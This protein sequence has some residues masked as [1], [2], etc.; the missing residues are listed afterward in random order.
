MRILLQEDEKI[1][2]QITMYKAIYKCR[3]CGEEFSTEEFE[4]NLF[5]DIAHFALMK[6][7]YSIHG[8]TLYA[9]HLRHN[10]IDGSVGF[11]DFQGF[12]KVEG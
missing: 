7:D 10:C 5:V 3:L 12:K 11:S 9:R 8:R 4:D 6:E 2:D 1:K